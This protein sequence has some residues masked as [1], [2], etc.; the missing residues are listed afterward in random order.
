MIDVHFLAGDDFGAA[1]A[2]ELSRSGCVER[3]QSESFEVPPSRWPSALVQV[4][5][6]RDDSSSEIDR[7]DELAFNL[8]R[9][10]LPVVMRPRAFRVGPL[11]VPGVSGCYRCFRRRQYQHGRLNQTDKKVESLRRTDR[12]VPV[13]G[14]LPGH[15]SLAAHLVRADVETALSGRTESR[16]GR[17]T[18][19]RWLSL[20]V[21]AGRLTRVDGCDR[22]GA[23][24]SEH[25]TWREIETFA[26]QL[27]AR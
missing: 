23:V 10:W 3:M 22:C 14:F 4:V 20:G 25:S 21:S 2:A 1:V 19:V 6:T 17:L 9:P 7:V 16:A 26:E 18:V 12:D 24:R 11:V 13:S 15:V 5:S 27:R 8:D